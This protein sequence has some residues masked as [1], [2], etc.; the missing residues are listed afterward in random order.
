MAT[1]KDVAQAAGVSVA[2]VSRVINNGPK[3]GDKTRQRVKKIMDELGYRPNANARALVTQQSATLGVVLSELTDPFFA[4]LAGGVQ[5][6]ARERNMQ[7]LLGTGFTKADTERRAIETIL[8]QRCTNLVVHSKGL[9]DEELISYTKNVP[10]MV[11]INRF[12][13]E[14]PE[15]CVWLDNLT[16]GAFATKH[17]LSLGHKKFACVTSEYDIEDP[18]LRAKGFEQEL[19]NADIS[20]ENIMY[21]HQIPNEVGGEAAA[22][23]L[24][25][26]GMNATAIFCYNDAMASGVISVLTDNGYRV[27]DDISVMGFDDVLLARFLR[28]KLTTMRYPIEMMAI[29][30]AEMAIMLGS[31]EA[32]GKEH[33]YIPTLIKR[34]S[35]S[36]PP[37]Q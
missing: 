17:L 6:V 20:L 22:Q 26:K 5:K 24:L 7:M 33:K 9:S 27:P 32:A 18:V 8:E 37:S 1:I 4:T 25:T 2:T 28:P 21:E 14:I 3:V 36:A 34:N 35:V 12:I 15:R 13:P 16:G 19:V 31:G 11:L 23:N 29:Q 30:A 10:G